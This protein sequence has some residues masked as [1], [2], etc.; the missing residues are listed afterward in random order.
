MTPPA[1]D[2]CRRALL[3]AALA[4]RDQALEDVYR[5]RQAF[6]VARFRVQRLAAQIVEEP[7]RDEDILDPRD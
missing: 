5:A 1:S 6:Q 3:D 7:V 2:D 4:A